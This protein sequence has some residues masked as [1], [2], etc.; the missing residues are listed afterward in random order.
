MCSAC[1]SVSCEPPLAVINKL[2]RGLVL[3]HS[4]SMSLKKIQFSCNLLVLNGLKVVC[5]MIR[6]CSTEGAS[7]TWSKPHMKA[8]SSVSESKGSVLQWELMPYSLSHSSPQ[9]TDQSSNEEKSSHSGSRK[10]Q[11]GPEWAVNLCLAEDSRLVLADE[12]DTKTSLVES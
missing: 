12:W 3:A 1:S 6:I 7:W 9:S 4:S 5:N 8:S 11:P 2:H 10:P